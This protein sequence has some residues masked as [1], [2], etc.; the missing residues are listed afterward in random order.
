MTLTY[1]LVHVDKPSLLKAFIQLPY[2]LYRDDPHWVPN[3]YHDEVS[4][5]NPEENQALQYCETIRFLVFAE[6]K[7]VGRIMGIIHHPYNLRVHEKAARFF[8]LDCIPDQGVAHMLIQAVE[9][10]ARAKGMTRIIGPFGFSDKDPQGAQIEGLEHL[11]VLGTPVN[12][13]YLPLLIENEG[14]VK[15]IDC[16]SYQIAIP[17]QIPLIYQQ[18][19]KRVSANPDLQLI[20]FSSKRQLKPYILPVLRLMNESYSSIYGFHSL[21]EQ[22]M[23]KLARQYLPVLDPAFVK[24]VISK[25][26]GVIAFVVAMPDMSVGIKK[27]RGRLFPFGFFYILRSMQSATQLTLLLGAIKPAFRGVG[28]S[29]LMGKS[30]IETAVKRGLTTIDSHLILETNYRM[31]RECEKLNG[32][33]YKR[34]RI[35]TKNLNET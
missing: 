12:P 20:E 25:T 2:T 30:I 1:S 18:V 27:A 6:H 10:W 24:V 15:E 14:Y 13:A 26:I 3:L 33:V 34:F 23:I 4:F 17:R 22:E 21:S 35:F 29:V 31:R 11:P 32:H 28:I 7:P 8:A 9:D 5:H 16:V 19:F